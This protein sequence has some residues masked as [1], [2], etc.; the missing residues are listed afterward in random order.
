MQNDLTFSVRNKAAYFSSFNVFGGIKLGYSGRIPKIRF[1]I[2][3][4]ISVPHI[5]DSTISKKNTIVCLMMVTVTATEECVIRIVYY[6]A[7]LPVIQDINLKKSATN[8]NRINIYPVGG[9]RFEF[10]ME[11]GV[12]RNVI[13]TTKTAHRGSNRRFKA[14]NIANNFNIIKWKNYKKYLCARGKQRYDDG[15]PCT[16]HNRYRERCT[17]PPRQRWCTAVEKR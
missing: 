9:T 15:S 11:N 1:V 8:F 7:W 17:T 16:E 6:S 13:N 14:C 3:I 2:R 10:H 12:S 4:S 5:Y